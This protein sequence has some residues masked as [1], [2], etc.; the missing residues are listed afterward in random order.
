MIFRIVIESSQ[1]D[2]NSVSESK[3]QIN[4]DDSYCIIVDEST[5]NSNS[6]SVINILY[7]NDPS[8]KSILLDTKYLEVNVNN[9]EIINSVNAMHKLRDNE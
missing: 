5:D 2:I 4:K 3:D 7:V 9:R 1:K 8:K 6:K